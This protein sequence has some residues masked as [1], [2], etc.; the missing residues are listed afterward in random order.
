MKINPIM[1]IIAIAIAALSGYGFFAANGGENYQLVLTIGA[2]LVLFV[3][4]GGTIAIKSATG[5]GSVANIRVLSAVFLVLFVVEQVLFSF[6]PFHLP[7]YI[8]ITGILLLIYIL[9]AYAVGKALE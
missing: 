1:L 8:I 7:P 2:S 6:V 5:R 4:L 3:T 9:I